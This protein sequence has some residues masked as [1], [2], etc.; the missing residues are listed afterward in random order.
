M[1][2]LNLHLEDLKTV[3]CLGAHA[4]DIEIGCAGL[5]LRLLERN[6]DVTVHCVVLSAPGDRKAEAEQSA[7]TLLERA[8]KTDIRIGDFEETLFPYLGADIKKYLASLAAQISPD[9]VLTHWCQDRHQDHRTVG[10]LTWTSFRDHLVLEYEIP[11]WD[12][13]MGQPN[14]FMP[15][16]KSLCSLKV[17]HLMKAFPSQARRD[18]F[19]PEVFWAL[20]RLRGMEARSPSGYAEGFY[21][22][23]IVLGC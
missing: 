2:S 14:T 9:L 18:W 21:C 20:L 5:L 10:E 1:R 22:R 13:D 16:D 3:L 17:E 19:S 8:R 11:K 7:Q 15:L 23:K 12:G 4:D 6:P